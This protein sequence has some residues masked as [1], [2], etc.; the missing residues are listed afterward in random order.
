MIF[1]FVKAYINALKN[2]TREDINEENSNCFTNDDGSIAC[3][4]SWLRTSV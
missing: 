2:H 4:F 3:I 1:I